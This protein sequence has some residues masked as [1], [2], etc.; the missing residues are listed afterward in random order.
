MITVSQSSCRDVYDSIDI[1][2][3]ASI[4][5]RKSI[6]YIED[7][8]GDIRQ[9]MCAFIKI[10]DTAVFIGTLFESFSLLFGS[11][12]TTISTQAMFDNFGLNEN[13]LTNIH[14]SYRWNKDR[15]LS[16]HEYDKTYL[17]M[18]CN[19]DISMTKDYVLTKF[20]D[21]F[22]WD[23]D[24]GTDNNCYNVEYSNIRGYEC[25][26]QTVNFWSLSN[27]MHFRID[28]HFCHCQC[29][30]WNNGSVASED[31]FG[32]YQSTNPE[33]TCSAT[34]DS[35]TNY[36]IG[37]VVRYQTCQEIYF[38]SNQSLQN[39]TTFASIDEYGNSRQLM[40]LFKQLQDNSTFIG[41]LVC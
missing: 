8:N 17:L 38:A 21:E 13:D 40:C 22:L 9:I 4:L 2:D 37:Q 25:N 1:K 23:S 30:K 11:F 20:Y 3:K 10:N 5:N 15:I 28:S 36:W 31:N 26:S 7:D 35:T 34:D 29:C 27:Y 6:H 41:T 24:I 18:T 32:F 12:N 39:I 19:F 14:E 33:F 16:M